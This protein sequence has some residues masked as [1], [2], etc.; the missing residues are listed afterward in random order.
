MLQ[1]LYSEEYYKVDFIKE[2][3]KKNKGA[4]DLEKKLES[5]MSVVKDVGIGVEQINI[6]TKVYAQ[7]VYESAKRKLIEDKKLYIKVRNDGVSCLGYTTHVQ[8]IKAAAEIVE[9]FEYNCLVLKEFRE[10][11]NI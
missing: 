8:D 10:K 1:T 3:I 9:T 5:E 7:R 2:R 11:Y 4:I 6:L